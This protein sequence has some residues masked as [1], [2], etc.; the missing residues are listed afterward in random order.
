[1]LVRLG[2]GPTL[3]GPPDTGL[4]DTTFARFAR[5][6]FDPATAK[7]L[8]VFV[9]GHDDPERFAARSRFLTGS[10]RVP[11][12]TW[13]SEQLA[14]FYGAL[15]KATSQALPGVALAVATPTLGDGPAGSEARKADL[16]GLDPSLACGRR[17]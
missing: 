4:D 15:A 6:A 5:E 16:A 13:R 14:A 10:G 12:L 9:G 3:L 7:S 8:P 17:A 2:R 1:M 11:W